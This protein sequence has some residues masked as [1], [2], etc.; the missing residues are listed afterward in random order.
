MNTQ[1]QTHADNPHGPNEAQAAIDRWF[2]SRGWKPL[3]FQREAW[4]AYRAGRSGLIHAPTGIGKT[5]AAAFGA[6]QAGLAAN[7]DRNQ[8]DR[9]APLTVLWVTPLRALAADTLVALQQAA[10]EF[11]LP[12]SVAGRTGD[13]PAAVKKRQQQR[14]PTVLVTTPESLHLLLSHAGA[15]ERFDRLELVVVD[16]WHE[17]MG[18]KRGVLVE[19]ALARLRTWRKRVRTW[20][21]SATLGNTEAALRAL[22]GSTA[23]QGVLIQGR[24]PKTIRVTS[25]RPEVVERF[26]WAG[27]LGLKLLPR[28]IAR[29]EAAGSTL[30]FTNTRSQTEIWY[31]AILEAQPDWRARVAL[32][33]GSLDR[34]ERERVEQG[35]REGALMAVICTSSLDL[36]VDF[37]PVDQVIQIGSPKGVARLMQRAGRSGHRPGLTSAIVCVPTHAFELVEVAAARSAIAT[38]GIEPR[39]PVTRPLDVLAQYLVTLSLGD[40]F[41]PS[42]LYRELRTTHA[43]QDLPRTE[44][45][46]ALDFVSTGGEALGAYS[47]FHKIIRRDGR[48]TAANAR[49]AGRHRMQIGTITADAAIVVKYLNG[50]RLGSVEERF[51]ARLKRGD[52]FVFAGRRLEYIRLRDMVLYVRRSRA[53]RG[54][55]PQ[56]LGGRMPLSSELAAAVRDQLDRAARGVADAPEMQALEPILELQARRSIIPGADELLLETLVSRDG[57]HLFLFPFAG[58]LVNEGLAA[59]L[60]YRLSRKRPL[61][62][63]LAANDYGLELLADR[64]IPLDALEDRRLF[65]VDRLVEDILDSVNAA[66]MGRRQFREIARV[67][68]LVFPGYPGRAKHGGQIQA[69]SSLLYNVFQRY[70]PDNLLL[71]QSTREVLERQLEYQRLRASLERMA[72]AR[73]RRVD[74]EQPTPLAFPIMVDRLR[75]RLSSEKLAERVSRMQLRLEKK[76]DDK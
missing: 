40:G 48:Y 18:S 21:L 62:L 10:A 11:G 72:R 54:P 67:A 31:Q 57:H 17:L 33:H 55:I 24:V 35:L 52:V 6:M 60:A 29:I 38:R 42:A 44:Y 45:D 15:R 51:I 20:G 13:T 58:R 47:E 41:R 70:A 66:E 50:R 8:P 16:E 63:S 76:A 43:F 25:I 28:V 64:E 71:A 22:L 61:T 49:I 30:V 14:L 56:W 69:S 37:S 7:A 73:L 27:H 65:T 3:A 34:R 12:W 39:V 5:C 59:L 74:L 9:P 36:G 46:W 23:D 2:R 1:T 75:S 26:P 32:H 68:G 53:P 4:R 19:L